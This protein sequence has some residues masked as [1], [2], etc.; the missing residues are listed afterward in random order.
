MREKLIE[1]FKEI[2]QKTRYI[3]M[4][5]CME[6]VADYLLANGVIVLPCK[7]GEYI[8][9]VNRKN[10]KIYIVSAKITNI[11]INK[12]DIV[13]NAPKSFYPIKLS[14]YIIKKNE[15]FYDFM[16][17]FYAGENPITSEEAEKALEEMK[18]E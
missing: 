17:D 13:I 12:N 10:G 7:V 11:K 4:E 14:E 8:S 6:K 1:L 5:E 15:E 2:Y 16:A 9:K 3:P 18:N